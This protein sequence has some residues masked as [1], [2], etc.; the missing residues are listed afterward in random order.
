MENVAA[1]I[2]RH[3]G[4]DDRRWTDGI[5][6]ELERQILEY[7]VRQVSSRMPPLPSIRVRA[8]RDRALL[9]E[10][11]VDW[12]VLQGGWWVVERYDCLEHL[13]YEARRVKGRRASRHWENEYAQRP[14]PRDDQ[15]D[16][17][18]YA[19]QHLELR[20]LDRTLARDQLT[21]DPIQKVGD[22]IAKARCREA[23][24]LLVRICRVI[25]DAVAMRLAASLSLRSGYAVVTTPSLV[26]KS[27]P[28]IYVLFVCAEHG[29][30][31]AGTVRQVGV[32]T[33][34]EHWC[35]RCHDRDVSR[36]LAVERLAEIVRVCL[37]AA[38]T[39]GRDAVAL[40]VE[41]C[42]VVGHALWES[43]SDWQKRVCLLETEAPAQRCVEIGE[44]RERFA[45]LELD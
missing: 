32:D 27:R 6:L 2:A 39:P 3:P 29:L 26:V 40:L 34:P 36:R 23:I 31:S 8:T 44:S 5:E 10:A 1:W 22:S 15:I 24:D 45:L 25:A 17:M 12:D 38:I 20:A 16:A 41:I 28:S 18:N 35:Q 13:E 42:L 37:E 4:G 33:A 9:V 14:M 43:T 30:V 11:W 19:R 7:Y 21:R